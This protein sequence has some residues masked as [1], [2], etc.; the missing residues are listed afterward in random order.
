MTSKNRLMAMVAMCVAAGTAAPT[1]AQT[2][3]NSTPTARPV[4]SRPGVVRQTNPVNSAALPNAIRRGAIATRSDRTGEIAGAR[5]G[6]S[7]TYVVYMRTQNGCGSGGCR[8][9]IWRMNGANAVEGEKLVVGRLPIVVLPQTDNGMPRLGVTAYDGARNVS[10]I[11]PAIFNGN[12]YEPDDNS[13]LAANSGRPLITA[14]M[15]RPF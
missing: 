2:S 8:A 6:N 4:Q 3:W 10:Y 11:A 13:E 5:I 12:T 7:N 14:A 15:L 9:Q 1:I